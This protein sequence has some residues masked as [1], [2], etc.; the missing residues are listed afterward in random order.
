[1]TKKPKKKNKK[2]TKNKDVKIPDLRSGS[3]KHALFYLT[4]RTKIKQQLTL[5]EEWLCGGHYKYYHLNSWCYVTTRCLKTAECH[6]FCG[7]VN[8]TE[9]HRD[10]CQS[11]PQGKD[12]CDKNFSEKTCKQCMQKLMHYIIM[13]QYTYVYV[14]NYSWYGQQYD[15]LCIKPKI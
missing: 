2:K 13:I 8:V 4:L 5:M 11:P 3:K 12:Q 7:S 9:E 15:P 14:L 1:M 6:H 10:I